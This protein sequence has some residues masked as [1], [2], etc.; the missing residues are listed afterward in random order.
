MNTNASSIINMIDNENII[1]TNNN[2]NNNNYNNVVDDCD[3]EI[4]DDENRIEN[5]EE[6]KKIIREKLKLNTNLD[7]VSFKYL[8]KL[9]K[10][11]K[12]EHY[13]SDLIDYG[14]S[15]A[16]SLNELNGFYY[17]KLNVSAYDLKKFSKLQVFIKQVTNTLKTTNNSNNTNRFVTKSSTKQNQPVKNLKFASTSTLATTPFVT[18]SSS[19]SGN[20]IGV[21]TWENKTNNKKMNQQQKSSLNKRPNS[22]QQST[23]THSISNNNNNIKRSKSIEPKNEENEEAND[24]IIPSVC[25]PEPLTYISQKYKKTKGSYFGPQLK[26]SQIEHVEMK[27]YNY[28]VPNKQ[29]N[30]HIEINNKKHTHRS[31]SS[32]AGTKQRKSISS[33]ETNNLNNENSFEMADIYV[34]ARK[35]PKLACE[36]KLNDAVIVEDPTIVI[37]QAK[38][39]VDGTEILRQVK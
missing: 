26:N 29:Q 13:M 22:K 31:V 36:L 23:S 8:Y 24:K 37:N 7:L 4:I 30:Q 18:S 28:G 1:N 21:P 34:F 33:V 17:E 27:N 10:F 11:Y 32:S 35:R 6:F 5:N 3:Q 16:M 19:S 9:L 39:A 14:F 25:H 15:T 38:L 2:K 20:N 12:L